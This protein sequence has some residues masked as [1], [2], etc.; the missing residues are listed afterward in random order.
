VTTLFLDRQPLT[1]A[2]WEK[3]IRLP[4]FRNLGELDAGDTALTA[5]T[6]RTLPSLPN[7]TVFSTRVTATRADDLAPLKDCAKLKR[8]TFNVRG[9]PA[10]GYAHLRGLG[11]ASLGVGGSGA[12][13]PA[14]LLDAVASMPGLAFLH[15]SDWDARAADP[16]RLKGLRYLTHFWLSQTELAPDGLASLAAW[17]ALWEVRIWLGQNADAHLA[18]LGKMPKLATLMY[19]LSPTVTDAGLAALHGTKSLTLIEC[20]GCPKLTAAGIQQLSA[21]IPGCLIKS[22]HGAFKGGSRQSDPAAPDKMAGRRKAAEWVCASG[23]NVVIRLDDGAERVIDRVAD[24]PQKFEL[25]RFGLRTRGVTDEALIGHLPALSEVVHLDFWSCHELTDASVTLLAKLPRLQTLRLVGMPGVTDRTLAAFSGHP[26][27]AL[28]VLSGNRVTPDGLKHLRTMKS[29]E[30]LSLEHLPVTDDWLAE[31]APLT[32]LTH[33]GLG[34]TAPPGRITAAGAAHLKG[35][36]RLQVLNLNAAVIDDGAM[37]PV[38]ALPALVNLDLQSSQV[39]DGGMELLAGCPRLTQIN[40]SGSRVTGAGVRHLAKLPVLEFAQL[41]HV[42]VGDEDAKELAASKSLKVVW[43]AFSGIGDEGAIALARM[44]QLVELDLAACPRVTDRTAAALANHPNLR[45]FGSD[46]PELTDAAARHFATIK[47]LRVLALPGTAV[48]DVSVPAISGLK[49]LGRLDLTRSKVTPAG[50]AA[51]KLALPNCG[52]QG[53]PPVDV[54]AE[55]RKALAWLQGVKA[56]VHLLL[57][58]DRWLPP[59]QIKEPLPPEFEIGRLSLHGLQT[60]TDTDLK[61]HLHGLDGLRHL[62]LDNCAK[63]TDDAAGLLVK[64]PKLKHLYVASMPGVTDRTF[65]ALAGHPELRAVVLAHTK[66]SDAAFAGFAAMLKLEHLNINMGPDRTLVTAKGLAELERSS[67]LRHLQLANVA[68]TPDHLRAMGRIAGLN[69]VEVN[70]CQIPAEG[71]DAIAGLK[72]L[73]HLYLAGTNVGDAH[74]RK[75]PPLVTVTDLAMRDCLVGDEGLAGLEKWLQLAT[76]TLDR[77]EVKGDGLK[78]LATCPKLA[79]VNLDGNPVSS[80]GLVA[81]AASPTLRQLRIQGTL[82]TDAAADALAATPRLDWLHA[83]GS[84][85]TERQCKALVGSASLVRLGLS[86][87]QVGDGHVKLLADKPRL[88]E[89][90]LLDTRVTDA[91][92]PVLRK[93]KHLTWLDLTGSRVTPTGVGALRKALPKCTVLP[94]GPAPVHVTAGDRKALQW[95]LDQGAEVGLAHFND[96]GRGLTVKKSVDEIGEYEWADWLV[97]HHINFHRRPVLNAKSVENLRGLTHLVNLGADGSPRSDE[98]LAALAELPMAGTLV[99]LSVGGTG[100]TDAGAKHLA[101][102]P[103]LHGV[104]LT[105]NRLSG[106]GAAHLRKLPQLRFVLWRETLTDDA[107]K[108]LKGLPL[109]E[110]HINGN[111]ELTDA[112]VAHLAGSAELRRLTVGSPKVTDAGLARVLPSLAALTTLWVG[113][114]NLGPKT[115]AAIGE[116]KSLVELELAGWLLDGDK[117]ADLR[118]APTVT[119]LTL[120]EVPGEVSDATLAELSKQKQLKALAFP[121]VKLGEERAVKL[122]KAL[123]DT[124][125]TTAEGVFVNGVK[126]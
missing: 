10:A 98:W 4:G 43:L 109:S 17:P 49:K 25:A 113:R 79:H 19:N 41:Y 5:A 104:Y 99:S 11:V 84:G 48:T 14:E 6:I 103:K 55:R 13:L 37:A 94:E 23:G 22:D 92:F 107:L 38:T 45:S 2:G 57:P 81:L 58:G 71:F 122:S 35:M 121:A 40:V 126:K 77:T 88:I 87:Q 24:L 110:L 112:G 15:L 9:M 116:C 97:P 31:V 106:D 91:S 117:L 86:G 61:A 74:M 95:A 16:G 34:L 85:V 52:I 75:L 102:F 20:W 62:D 67:S 54:M 70:Q 1:D 78:H 105:G 7:L 115:L 39:G 65:A 36:K 101:A 33:L 8:L 18:N 80:A 63:V 3:L 69:K 72:N 114:E 66:L 111:P 82:M 119:R 76:L 27:L 21:A 50:F 29:L 42:P 93:L 123:P 12:P 125:V 68:I 56:E 26:A 51:L 53:A 32:Q 118:L 90:G 46:S 44:P 30:Q 120:L 96:Y 124:A 47:E 89:L 83:V 64:L 100:L 60:L 59:D 108:A 73:T 28:L